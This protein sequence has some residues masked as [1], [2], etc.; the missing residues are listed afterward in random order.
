M[1]PQQNTAS[2]D[3]GNRADDWATGPGSPGILAWLDSPRPDKISERIARDILSDIVSREL[4]PGTTLSSESAMLDRYGVGRASLRE[5]LRIL[6]IHGAIKIKPGSRGGPVVAELTSRDFGR[7]SSFYF[8]AKRATLGDLL[9]ARLALEPI[10]AGLAAR[11]ITAEGAAALRRSL[12]VHSHADSPARPP[13][14][15]AASTFHAIVNSLS[16]NPVLDL[17]CGSLLDIQYTRGPDELWLDEGGEVLRAHERI[18]SA[19][20]EGN[21]ELSEQRMRR[22]IQAQISLA[23]QSQPGTMTRLIDWL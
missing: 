8:H 20:I 2:A 10:V 17:M 18:A 5:A 19:I 6:E 23:R 21:A 7:A 4:A 9:S 13:R 3:D 1:K 14:G 16:G 22:H 12:T 15:A 11:N